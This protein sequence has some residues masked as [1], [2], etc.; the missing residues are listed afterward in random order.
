MPGESYCNSHSKP[1]APCHGWLLRAARSAQEA[2]LAGQLDEV[3]LRCA[4][5]RLLL[6]RL[7]R[8]RLGAASQRDEVL[9]EVFT[10]MQAVQGLLDEQ[11]KDVLVRLEG[12]TC[13]AAYRDARE[14]RRHVSGSA[15][16][17]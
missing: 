12:L 2:A 17:V 1:E 7:D 16:L 6:Y 15:F 13:A 8:S 11:R 3:Q 10:I 14:P 5:V 4:V 9:K